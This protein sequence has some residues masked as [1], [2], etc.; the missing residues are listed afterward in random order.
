MQNRQSLGSG[1][2]DGHG[3]GDQEIDTSRQWRSTRVFHHQEPRLPNRAEQVPKASQ[4]RT[5][6]FLAPPATANLQGAEASDVQSETTTGN[7][8]T[9][10]VVSC[11]QRFRDYLLGLVIELED[12]ARDTE[13]SDGGTALREVELN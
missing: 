6:H 13:G 12:M 4:P 9:R 1:R 3:S 5:N 10:L 2:S 7:V 11:L 8:A